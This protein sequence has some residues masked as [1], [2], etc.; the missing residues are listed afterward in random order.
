M[1][2]ETRHWVLRD[3]R[4]NGNEEPDHGRRQASCFPA[5]LRSIF[6][7][8]DEARIETWSEAE[9]EEFT[10]RALWATCCQGVAGL[11]R[12]RRPRCRCR[13]ATAIFCGPRP[14]RTPICW[15]TTI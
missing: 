4:N 15:F 3:L 5:F 10:L 2:A 12:R 1:I 7:R 11:R 9:W 13:F 6:D 8:M 14:A